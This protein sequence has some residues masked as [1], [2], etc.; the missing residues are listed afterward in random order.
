V[1]GKDR[2]FQ[3]PTKKTLLKSVLRPILPGPNYKAGEG[4]AGAWRWR[5]CDAGLKIFLSAHGAKSHG[6]R[7]QR[8]QPVKAQRLDD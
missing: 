8:M 3:C 1:L 6:E 4:L 2:I 7:H 5:Q